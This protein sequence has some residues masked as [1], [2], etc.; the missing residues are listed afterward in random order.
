MIWYNDLIRAL[1]ESSIFVLDGKT[2]QCVHYESVEL[3]PRKKRMVMDM[4]VF[5]KHSD[6]QIRNDFI[7]CQIDICSVEVRIN[8]SFWTI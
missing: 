5:D 7:D 1:G 6:V 8:C 3:Y 2:Q 4:A